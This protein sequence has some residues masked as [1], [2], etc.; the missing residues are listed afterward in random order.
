MANEGGLHFNIT[1]DIKDIKEKLNEVSLRIKGTSDTAVNE[2]NKIDSN[3]KKIAI[4]FASVFS[5]RAAAGFAKQ[6]ANVRGEFQQLEVAF[7][8]MLGSKD[9]ADELMAKVVETAAKTPFDLQGVANGAKQLLA[10]GSASETVTDEL[11]MLGNIASGLSIPL[12]DMVYLYGTTRTQGRMFTQDLRQFMGRGIPLAEELA[13]QFGVTKDKVGELVTAGK[14]GFPEVQ[15]A[16]QDMTGEGGKFY[17]LMD[18]QSKTISGQISN[19][20]DSVQQMMNDIGKSNEGIISDV[21]GG[22]SWA[23]ENYKRVAEVIME[24]IAAYGAYK[25]ALITAT[26]IQNAHTVAVRLAARSNTALAGSSAIAATKTVLLHNAQRSLSSTM[27]GLSTMVNPYTLIA[28]GVAVLGVAIY[29]VL[30]YQT[31]YEKS[32]KEMNKSKASAE[33]SIA[34]EIDSLDEL[35]GKLKNA[36]EG[37]QEYKDIKDSIQKKYGDY[38]KAYSDEKGAVLDVADAY[39][40]LRQSITDAT[41]AKAY[42][43]EVTRVNAE[44]QDTLS[45]SLKNLRERVIA[46]VAKEGKSGVEANAIYASLLGNLTG[47]SSLSDEAKAYMEKALAENSSVASAYA[48]DIAQGQILAW[49]K[50][51]DEAGRAILKIKEAQ[52]NRKNLLDEAKQLFGGQ[53]VQ[54]AAESQETEI[55]VYTKLAEVIDGI[56]TKTSE[57][58]KVRAQVA[59]EGLTDDAEKQIKNI[60]GEIE[61]F[62]KTYKTMTGKEY[63]KNVAKVDNRASEAFAKAEIDAQNRLTKELDDIE[64]SRITDK[65]ELREYDLAHTLSAIEDERQAYIQLAIDKGKSEGGDIGNDA[66]GNTTINGQ[67]VDDSAYMQL[68]ANA[69]SRSE[70]ERKKAEQETL[71]ALLEQYKTYEQRKSDIEN[72]YRQEREIMVEG[73]ANEGALDIQQEAEKKALSSLNSEYEKDI[74]SSSALISRLMKDVST[75][76]RKSIQDNIKLFGQLLDYVNNEKGA[77]KPEGITDEVISKLR[78]SPEEMKALYEQLIDL[79]REYSEKTSY[80]FS[81]F[82]NGFKLLRNAKTD[83]E[84]ELGK[85]LLLKGADTALTAISGIT[86][87][88]H[89]LAEATGDTSMEKFADGLKNASNVLSGVL[90]GAKSGGVWGAIAGGV[91]SIGQNIANN[92]IESRAKAHQREL[93]AIDFQQQ[94]NRLLRERNYLEEEYSSIWGDSPLSRAK[95]AFASANSALAEYNRIIH[96]GFVNTYEDQRNYTTSFLNPLEGLETKVS[97]VLGKVFGQSNVEAVEK[98]GAKV[99]NALTF[100]L[101]NI[102]GKKSNLSEVLASAEARGLNNLQAMAIQQSERKWYKIGSRDK[103]KTLYDIA[104]EL[105]GNDQAGEFDV[106]AAKIFLETNKDITEEQRLQIQNAINLKEEY[107][108]AMKIIEDTAAQIVGGIADDMGNAIFDAVE[109]GADAWDD[110]E[111]SGANAVKN[112]AKMMLQEFLISNYM[113]QYTDSI[114][115]ALGQGNWGAINDIIGQMATQFPSMYQ[116]GVDFTQQVYAAAEQAGIDMSSLTD[117][118]REAVASGIATASQDS[119]DELNG[120]ATAIQGFVADIAGSS[121]ATRSSVEDIAHNVS[122]YLAKYADNSYETLG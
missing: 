23:V 77:I 60:E 121:E 80:P 72:K 66:F 14:V 62:E 101:F 37:T 102:G 105:W 98:F 75:Q 12:G 59:K 55:K 99:A 114:K 92:E 107:D 78:Q 122:E 21:I 76:S 53:D 16:L 113:E 110:F 56:T 5:L 9:K 41:L 18:E 79:Q 81:N 24:I 31:A 111:A 109:N 51:Y 1:A 115:N 28:A 45:S 36:K 32:V 30:T 103:Y 4:G 2:G 46:D 96:E 3:I 34:V 116:A 11:K 19:L 58:V 43:Q 15:K 63:G 25:A 20:G 84:R 83:T 73:G 74:M 64:R 39:D 108:A 61:A 54:T 90:N 49:M 33:A 17:N 100:G 67:R 44:Y 26:A 22:A 94:Y 68:S 87:K 71:D 95:E 8:T 120:R 57:L 70:D 50:Q 85:E 7:T 88:V 118:S 42:E 47:G 13:K 86:D 40:V 48:T 35:Y 112:L 65:E 89:E 10:Y 119:V 93:D 106:E 6:V 29:K 82:I 91:M 117:S 97:N 38:I 104:P 27:K 52:S 69:I